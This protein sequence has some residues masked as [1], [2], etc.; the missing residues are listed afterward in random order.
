MAAVEEE[1]E[2]TQRSTND[3]FLRDC[4]ILNE[5]LF[6]FTNVLSALTCPPPAQHRV[7]ALRGR[8]S[9]RSRGGGLQVHR[10]GV[11]ADAA[12]AQRLH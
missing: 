4:R 10:R 5:Q 1:E 6:L 3:V 2:D 12:D 8:L 9:D 7:P 11:V